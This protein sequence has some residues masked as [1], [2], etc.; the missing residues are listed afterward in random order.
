MM[1]RSDNFFAEQSLL[2]VSARLLNIMNDEKIIDT[3]LKQI[4]KISRK[5]QAG[6]MDQD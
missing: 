2:M 4:L 3:L 5:S 6:R 1:Y